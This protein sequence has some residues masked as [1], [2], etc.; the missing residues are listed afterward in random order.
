MAN[1]LSKLF[2]TKSDRDLKDVKPMLDATLKVYPEIQKLSNDELRAKTIEFKEIINKEV[3]AEE[4]ELASLRE[5]IENEYDMPV[6][7]KEEIYKRI[8]KLEKD[9]YEKT[10]KVL[11]QILPEAFSV[12][13][14]TAR[15][16]AENE[17]VVVTATDHDR[18]LAVK[19]DNVNIEGDKAIYKNSWMAGGNMIK[20]D[21]VHYDVQLIGGIVLHNGKI[22]EMATGEGKTLV[23]TLPVYLNL[24]YQQRIRL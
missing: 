19:R 5:R 20:W 3:A 22:A 21:M 2:G 18:E 23:A 16:F 15:R 17:E 10:Q 11:N 14:E 8:D 9:S 12:V 1:F 6:N 7:E 13:K 24:R 4:N